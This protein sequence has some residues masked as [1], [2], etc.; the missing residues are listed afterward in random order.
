MKKIFPM[1]LILFVA[2]QGLSASLYVSTT[3]SGTACSSVSPCTKAQ[4]ESVT[5]SGDTIYFK[6]TDTWTNATPPVLTAIA[7][8][9]YNGSSYGVG[10][11]ATLQATGD[12]VSIGHYAVVAL[13]ANNVTFRGFIIDANLKRGSGIAIGQ[14]VSGALSNV[15]VDSCEVKNTSGQVGDWNYGIHITNYSSNTTSNVTVS[16]NT[17]HDTFHECIAV[18]PSWTTNNNHLNNI[19][20]SGNTLYNCGTTVG[21]QTGPGISVVSDSNN[22]TVTLNTI[23]SGGDQGIWVRVSPDSDVT[24]GPRNFVVSR[25]FVHDNASTGISVTNGRG[26]DLG[27]AIFSNIVVNNGGGEI[28]IGNEGEAVNDFNSTYPINVYNNTVYNTGT[29]AHGQINTCPWT[30]TYSCTAGKPTVDY[31]N[32]IV[33]TTQSLAFGDRYGVASHSNNLLYRSSGVGD[34]LV[35]SPWAMPYSRTTATSWEASVKTS[36]P[37]FLDTASVFNWQW[38]TNGTLNPLFHS[39][40]MAA[41]IAAGLNPICSIGAWQTTGT[42]IW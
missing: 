14:L 20:V 39:G 3:G 38:I 7:G 36:N 21:G 31:R 27:G 10:T 6:N 22:T 11:K 32:N 1:L 33:Y 23:S 25:N 24:L 37:A 18:Y 19:T 13:D 12:M 2:A 17:V 15:T 4:A 16:N 28:S 34:D 41:C 9:T 8:V 35:R 29:Y 40:N 26:F 42:F 5:T 30:G